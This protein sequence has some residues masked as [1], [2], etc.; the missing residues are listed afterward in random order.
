LNIAKN[1]QDTIQYNRYAK[2]W[3]SKW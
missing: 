2:Q 3:W 1:I